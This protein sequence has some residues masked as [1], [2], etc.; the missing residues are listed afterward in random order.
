MKKNII[1]LGLGAFLACGTL[2]AMNSQNKTDE[3][4]ETVSSLASGDCVSWKFQKDALG[5]DEIK[6]TN[7]CSSE[8]KVSYKY[9][10]GKDR[11]VS[12][13]FRVGAGQSSLWWPAN[14]MKD[15]DYEFVD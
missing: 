6:I 11:W 3:K 15:F 14:S 4:T 12:V 7:N 10:N 13:S 9:W 8:I 1:V 2:F 5:L